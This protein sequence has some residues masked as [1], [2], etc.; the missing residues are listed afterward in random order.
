MARHVRETLSRRL[1]RAQERAPA[2]APTP[3][4]ILGVRRQS[5]LVKPSPRTWDG[6]YRLLD[7][8]RW[9][10]LRRRRLEMS[11]LVVAAGVAAAVAAAVE[12]F[13]S[14][15]QRMG[16]AWGVLGRRGLRI[17]PR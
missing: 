8:K 12:I 14:P 17:G 13:C 3:A 10:R 7:V 1:R 6:L 4:G 11:R 15:L 16:R 2:L 9:R 5:K